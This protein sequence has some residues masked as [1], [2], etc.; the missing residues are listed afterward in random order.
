M[1]SEEI[2]F[3]TNL[4]KYMLKEVKMEMIQHTMLN[5]VLPQTV[6]SDLTL[7]LIEESEF[8]NSYSLLLNLMSTMNIN[9]KDLKSKFLT[10]TVLGKLS[11]QFTLKFNTDA[12]FIMLLDT[13][14]LAMMPFINTGDMSDSTTKITGVF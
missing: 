11:S 6:S 10:I 9:Y 1:I 14:L 2:I 5:P 3:L 12:M 8:L 4:I 7:E 13:I